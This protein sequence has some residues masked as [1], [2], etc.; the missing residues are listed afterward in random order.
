MTS[1]ERQR[2]V[3]ALEKEFGPDWMTV[4]QELGTEIC[5]REWE[6][7]DPAFSPSPNGG[8]AGKTHGGAI[9]LPKW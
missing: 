4:A 2:A 1:N 5:A 9:A 6:G 7:T 8:R 3:A